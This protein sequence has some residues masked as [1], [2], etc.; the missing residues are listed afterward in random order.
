MVEDTTKYTPRTSRVAR[1]HLLRLPLSTG[2]LVTKHPRMSYINCSLTVTPRTRQIP[3]NRIQGEAAFWTASLLKTK[4]DP[5]GL[6]GT[7]EEQV[8]LPCHASAQLILF[9]QLQ[10]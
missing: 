6:Q 2:N 4:M 1:E 3:D 5:E 9:W 7:G 10:I 8:A